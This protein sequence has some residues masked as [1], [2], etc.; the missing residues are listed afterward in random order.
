MTNMTGNQKL[1]ENRLAF[2]TCH[3]EKRE[4]FPGVEIF[5]GKP[6]FFK[7]AFLFEE[8]A[9]N[10]VPADFQLHVLDWVSIDD[11]FLINSGWHVSES[12]IY[13]VLK[14]EYGNWA[15]NP[16]ITVE[17]IL[18]EK[19]LVRY[20]Q[21]QS[22]GFSEEAFED[23]EFYPIMLASSQK[24]FNKSN[25]HFYLASLNGKPAGVA[26]AYFTEKTLGIYSVATIAEFRGVG[27]STSLMKTVI[28]QGV[29]HSIE[30]VTLQTMA[31][32]YA[33]KFYKKLGF[34]PAFECRIFKKQT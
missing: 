32:S 13:M 1:L 20:C 6:A 22:L 27:V 19:D 30:C 8:N 21:T 23:D 4:S 28:E 34:E 14:S 2:I 31:E 7:N 26:L 9:I 3:R 15:V 33:E 29:G 10:K 11:A 16:K 12:M 5:H 17:K 24:N 18:V 25:H